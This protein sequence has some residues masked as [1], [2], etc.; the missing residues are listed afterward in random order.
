MIDTKDFMTKAKAAKTFEI[1]PV[2]LKRIIELCDSYDEL[3]R[4]NTKLKDAIK[5][6]GKAAISGMD[7]AI[8]HGS[9]M[10]SEALQLK[11]ESSPDALE[12]ERAAN[13]VLTDR[14]DDLERK[15]K[16]AIET[17][18]GEIEGAECDYQYPNYCVAHNHKRPCDQ[19]LLKDALKQ[20]RGEK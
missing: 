10:F 16:I 4:E 3:V 9:K 7:A 18:E 17:I 19:E 12:S 13:A 6:Q 11:Q 20:I 15:I 8:Y 1:H 2:W 14:I 5:I